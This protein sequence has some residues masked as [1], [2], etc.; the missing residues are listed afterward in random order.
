MIAVLAGLALAVAASLAS[1][2]AAAVAGALLRIALAL[3]RAGRS[4][5]NYSHVVGVAF[6]SAEIRRDQLIDG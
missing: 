4:G 1:V 5:L 6:G 3:I 2:G